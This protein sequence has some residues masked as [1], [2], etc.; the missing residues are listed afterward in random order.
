M[1][2]IN[3]KREQM[4]VTEDITSILKRHHSYNKILANELIDYIEGDSK[5]VFRLYEQNI[6]PI[7]PMLAD[8]LSERGTGVQR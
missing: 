5:N 6:G 8:V 4:S 7:T 3:R 1:G 2:V